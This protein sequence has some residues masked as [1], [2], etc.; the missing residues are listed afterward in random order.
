MQD[1]PNTLHYIP[2]VTCKMF[3]IRSQLSVKALEIKCSNTSIYVSIDTVVLYHKRRPKRGTDPDKPL[4]GIQPFRLG[5]GGTIRV[6]YNG[7]DQH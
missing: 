1:V 3:P 2:Q 6:P 5:G 4:K 7:N